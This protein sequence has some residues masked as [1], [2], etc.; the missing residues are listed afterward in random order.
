MDIR[1]KYKHYC[2]LCCGDNHSV[3][4]VYLND[5]E[6]VMREYGI[7][8]LL[9]KNMS[10]LFCDRCF[11]ESGYLDLVCPIMSAG[12]FFKVLHSAISRGDKKFE[13]F[14]IKHTEGYC[15]ICGMF[16]EGYEEDESVCLDDTNKGTFN[17][18]LESIG[19]IGSDREHLK[20][21]CRR[22]YEVNLIKML[23]FDDLPLH[24]N[25]IH[26]DSGKDI[27]MDRFSK[28]E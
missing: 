24:L 26:T 16:V 5:I 2:D 1:T 6:Q 15:R 9:K 14:L 10:T 28:N 17:Y 8:G 3:M 25:E 21:T 4:M 11:N 7:Q 18:A 12:L 19:G 20:I 13:K 27:L 23:P 22:C